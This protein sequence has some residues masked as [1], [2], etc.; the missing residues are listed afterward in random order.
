[1]FATEIFTLKRQTHAIR[2]IAVF[3]KGFVS[4]VFWKGELKHHDRS[5]KVK[6]SW[7][8]DSESNVFFNMF[9]KIILK[10]RTLFEKLHLWVLILP[11][12]G[13][14]GTFSAH[15]DQDLPI[16]SDGLSS[17]VAILHFLVA[18][19]QY[20]KHRISMTSDSCSFAENENNFRLHH[21]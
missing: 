10:E 12:K 18:F 8:T 21:S 1:M 20:G 5:Q 7:F 6:F 19:C 9:R 17:R 2:F 3:F 13:D 14:K 15:S 16:N 4:F 11:S